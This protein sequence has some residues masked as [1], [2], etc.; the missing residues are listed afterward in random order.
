MSLFLGKKKVKIFYVVS[1][2]G[3]DLQNIFEEK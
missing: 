1:Q 3:N 2:Y